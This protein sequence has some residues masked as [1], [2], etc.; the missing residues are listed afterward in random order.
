VDYAF[1]KLLIAD[2]QLYDAIVGFDERGYASTVLY[3]R[4]GAG[5]WRYLYK[6]KATMPAITAK[7]VVNIQM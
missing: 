5:D 1:G 2:E 3:L 4:Q 7:K 6:I